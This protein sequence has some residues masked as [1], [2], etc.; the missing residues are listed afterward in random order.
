MI[1]MSQSRPETSYKE[2]EIEMGSN[3][4]YES[5]TIRHT[6]SRSSE[7][8]LHQRSTTYREEPVYELPPTT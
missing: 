3:Q 2:E 6:V 4:A 7:S 5:V 1:Q 8:Q